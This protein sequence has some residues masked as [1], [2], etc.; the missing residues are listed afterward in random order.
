[1]YK[2]GK[3]FYI[4]KENSHKIQKIEVS[5]IIIDKNGISYDYDFADKKPRLY[6]I[7]A[8]NWIRE[9]G[10]LLKF[11]TKKAAM[12]YLKNLKKESELIG[13]T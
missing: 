12:E 9:N 4:I 1:M 2:I 11:S 10:K 5:L 3:K 8:I 7:W 6:S 13:K